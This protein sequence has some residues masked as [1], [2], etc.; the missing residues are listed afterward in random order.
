[1]T[2][3]RE[4][5]RDGAASRKAPTSRRFALKTP[6]DLLRRKE[7]RHIVGIETGSTPGKFG[8]ALVEVSGN[9]DETVLYLLGF[10]SASLGRELEAALEALEKERFDSEELAG[11]NFLVLHHLSKLYEDVLANAGMAPQKVD[12]IGLKCIETGG[13]TF[14]EDPGV[15]SELTERVVASRFRIAMSGSKD[16]VIPVKG[17][18]LQG[19]VG[20]MIDRFG[21]DEEVRE[22]VSVAL[23]AN[24]SIFN[25]KVSFCTGVEPAS[26]PASRGKERPATKPEVESKK[27]GYLCGEFFFPA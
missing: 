27:K 15:F 7:K 6:L 3:L 11:I 26:K 25:Q 4:R 24:E 9:G 21:L 23:L 17:E 19:M 5:F 20:D 1:M 13:F 22:A 2:G 14:P 16:G 12:L 18:L 10:K 8:A